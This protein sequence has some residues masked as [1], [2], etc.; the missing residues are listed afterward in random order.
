[1]P[2]ANVLHRFIAKF[3]DFLIV[4]ACAKLIPPIGFFAGVAYLLI[5]DGLWEGQ[6]VGKRIIGLQTVKVS[7]GGAGSFQESII[8]NVPLAMGWIAGVIPYV[9]WLLVGGVIALEALLIIG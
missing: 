2:K 3:L 8:R 9:G 5:A 1:M 7:G 6:S 4:A